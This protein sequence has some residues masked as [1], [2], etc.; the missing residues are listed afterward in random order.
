M[1]DTGTGVIVAPVVAQA[2]RRGMIMLIGVAAALLIGVA[3][4]V[5]LIIQNSSSDDTG[6]GLGHI[7]EY[8]NSRPEEIVR[9]HMLPQEGSGATTPQHHQRFVPH[10]NG[11]GNG[12]V[13]ETP[14][15]G[16]KIKSDE[17]EDMANKNSAGTQRCYIR[18]Q[19][20]AAGIEIADL[21]RLSVTLTI[22]KT[23]AVSD[24]QFSEKTADTLLTCLRTQIKLWKFRESPGGLYRIVL[25]FGSG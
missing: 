16:T 21:K 9:A 20:G 23:G 10:T 19:R 2:H 13:D 25:A 3:V 22:D 18:A 8:D 15:T 17:V 14:G 24:V 12:T 1:G 4:A 6:G 7:K 5:V 11:N